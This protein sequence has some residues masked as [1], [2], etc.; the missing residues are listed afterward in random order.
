MC[1]CM[2][3]CVCLCLC[4]CACVCV[5]MCACVCACVF[6]FV[7]SSQLY[8]VLAGVNNCQRKL[9]FA[10]VSTC[11]LEFAGGSSCLLHFV[12]R[13]E[14]QPERDYLKWAAVSTH[15]VLSLTWWH[16]P[17]AVGSYTRP[18]LWTG[19]GNN[20]GCPAHRGGASWSSRHPAYLRTHPTAH[21]LHLT[22]PRSYH[23]PS[24][25]PGGQT[26][27]SCTKTNDG[28]ECTVHLTKLQWL[29]EAPSVRASCHSHLQA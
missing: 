15:L 28:N 22:I 6:V 29:T 1:I 16:R 18:W 7:W 3:V 2:Y 21:G 13:S 25:L 11:L 24:S 14:Q 5:H 20:G 17:H 12:C 10:R 8:S 9:H 23:S 26:S 27:S 4:A 19:Q